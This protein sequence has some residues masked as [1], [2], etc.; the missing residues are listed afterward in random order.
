MIQKSSVLLLI[1]TAVPTAGAVGANDGLDH[2]EVFAGGEAGYPTYRIPAIA[3]TPRGTVLAFA[4]GRAARDDHARN[5]IVLKRSH[6]QGASWGPVQVIAQDGTNA[7]NNPCVAVLPGSGRVLLMFQHY[8][9]STG[10]ERGALPGHRGDRVCR[11]ILVTS[12]DDGATWSECRDITAST[13][14]P[15]YVTSVASGPGRVGASVH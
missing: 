14:R 15:E 4:E 10:G 11:N 8:P 1:L 6:D 2:I 7:L 13:K 5:D 3:T 12:D 9:E